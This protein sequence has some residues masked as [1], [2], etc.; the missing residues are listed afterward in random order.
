MAQ[1]RMESW[2]S[3]LV[4]RNGEDYV[5][6]I[7][8]AEVLRSIDRIIEDIIGGRI[9]Y[10]QYGNLL[11]IPAIFDNLLSYCRSRASTCFTE[12]FCL[13]YTNMA[14]ETGQLQIANT[15]YFPGSQMPENISY[16]AQVYD[17]NLWSQG[18]ATISQQTKNNL[19]TAIR[20][21]NIEY[22]KYSILA[23]ILGEVQVSRNI[24]TLQW[25]TNGLKQ[26][27][28]SNNKLQY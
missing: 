4:D 9:N 28:R 19:N 16:A 15:N 22:N 18:F 20:E 23:N 26:Y 13:N 8:D 10:D 3:R 21:K 17:V 14:S 11:L 27:I 24:F 12:L 25:N 5:K 1:R 6:N 2:L 7:T